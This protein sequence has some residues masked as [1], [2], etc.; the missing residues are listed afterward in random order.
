MR[1]DESLEIEIYFYFRLGFQHET[2]AYIIKEKASWEVKT[3]KKNQKVK[4]HSLRRP[5]N[6]VN[7]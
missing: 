1:Y 3:R 6:K 4:H 2:S 7:L 5:P